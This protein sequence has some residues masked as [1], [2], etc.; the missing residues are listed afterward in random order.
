MVAA[1][2]MTVGL[3]TL[4]TAIVDWLSVWGTKFRKF[5]GDLPVCG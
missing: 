1:V 3:L 4:S 5:S 2:K